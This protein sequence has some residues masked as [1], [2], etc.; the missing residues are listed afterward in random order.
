MLSVDD[1]CKP[2]L[3]RALINH[4]T[5]KILYTECIQHIKRK[6]ES[7]CTITLYHVPDF[8]L[9]RPIYTHAHAIRYITEKLRRGNF[10]VI[11]D[12]SV[13]HIDWDARIKEVCRR[14]TKKPP[15]KKRAPRKEEP[16]SVRLQRL[17][18]K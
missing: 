9:G 8:L 10:D 14:K 6:H 7:G 11:V 15:A 3:K 4:E 12:G 5:Y 2:L 17:L 16:L 18:K 13:L 1:L